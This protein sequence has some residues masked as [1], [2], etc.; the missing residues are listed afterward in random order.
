MKILNTET[1]IHQ[2]ATKQ[3]CLLLVFVWGF[4]IAGSAQVNVDSLKREVLL[5]L[6]KEKVVFHFVC[7]F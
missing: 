2:I 1:L 7:P 5:R 3:W 6:E 4:G